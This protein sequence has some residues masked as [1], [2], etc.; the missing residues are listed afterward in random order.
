M[1]SLACNFSLQFTNS[2]TPSQNSARYFSDFKSNKEVVRSLRALF[3]GVHNEIQSSEVTSSAGRPTPPFPLR[4]A[5][6]LADFVTSHRA[7]FETMVCKLKNSA[8]KLGIWPH[9][10]D[11][12]G[13]P[14]CAI[15]LGPILQ[16]EG[17]GWDK[18]LSPELQQE[19]DNLWYVSVFKVGF[20][21]SF[22]FK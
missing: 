10:L 1:R 15:A 2:S 4:A 22:R 14:P 17:S 12:L 19:L 8:F 3:Q 21:I 20:D 11:F 18:L 5:L 7:L 6:D 16:N 13:L 9:V